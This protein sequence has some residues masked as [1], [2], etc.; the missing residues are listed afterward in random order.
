MRLEPSL[1]WF[2]G[3]LVGSGGASR[4][5]VS[6]LEASLARR[7]QLSS[8]REQRCSTIETD[9]CISLDRGVGSAATAAAEGHPRRPDVVSS[10][11]PSR[12]DPRYSARGQARLALAHAAE[13]LLD[14][15]R[16]SGRGGVCGCDMV[17]NSMVR[18]GRR[19]AQSAK[20]TSATARRVYM[21]L[22]A[23]SAVGCVNKQVSTHALTGVSLQP[24]LSPLF[25]AS[26]L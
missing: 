4:T 21:R 7:R 11:K 8:C 25:A 22:P 10:L 14:R 13:P 6:I 12:G 19:K 9:A 2:T 23:E 5:G 16:G 17:I 1:A 3:G 15:G 20:R 24:Q 18:P 26:A